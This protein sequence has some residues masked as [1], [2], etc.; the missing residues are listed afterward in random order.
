MQAYD[1][2]NNNREKQDERNRE[3]E[4]LFEPRPCAILLG[5]GFMLLLRYERLAKR[6]ADQRH[7][8]RNR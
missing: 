8:A 7:L 5:E 6:V 3:D 4:R 2:W 1:R